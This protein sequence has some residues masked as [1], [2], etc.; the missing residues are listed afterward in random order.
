MRVHGYD[1]RCKENFIPEHKNTNEAH[2]G[3]LENEKIICW[4]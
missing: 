2:A 3:E 1:A 4:F